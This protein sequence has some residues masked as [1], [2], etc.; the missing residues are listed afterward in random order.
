[1]DTK[2]P[3]LMELCIPEEREKQTVH[4]YEEAVTAREDSKARKS[5]RKT[6]RQGTPAGVTVPGSVARKK[7]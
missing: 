1:M 6:R 7:A 5:D 3:V 2:F 4:I